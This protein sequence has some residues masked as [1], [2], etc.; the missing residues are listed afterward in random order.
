MPWECHET[1]K[2]KFFFIHAAQDEWCDEKED[3]RERCRM[4]S[5]QSVAPEEKRKRGSI[6][7]AEERAQENSHACV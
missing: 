7:R 5:T 4:T 3:V 2:K 6:F 1:G